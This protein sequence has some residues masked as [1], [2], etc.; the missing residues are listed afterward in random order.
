MSNR[1]VVIPEGKCLKIPFR[2]NHGPVDQIIPVLFEPEE[3]SLG[4]QA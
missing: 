2:V 1:N 4:P 3:T